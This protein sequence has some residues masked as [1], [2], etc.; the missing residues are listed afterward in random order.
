MSLRFARSSPLQDV[1]GLSQEMCNVEPRGRAEHRR[2]E[3]RR[4]MRWQV[5]RGTHQGKILAFNIGKPLMRKFFFVGRRG[6]EEGRG[7]HEEAARC[8][9]TDRIVAFVDATLKAYRQVENY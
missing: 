1:I 8:A 7:G 6:V 4:S 9:A 5:P 2:D 3:L